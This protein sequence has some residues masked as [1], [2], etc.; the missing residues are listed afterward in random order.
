MS[1]N[2]IITSAQGGIVL[3]DSKKLFNL[4]EASKKQGNHIREMEVLINII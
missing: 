1:P 4:L 2:K 3:T